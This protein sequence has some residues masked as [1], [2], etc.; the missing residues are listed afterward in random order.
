MRYL[1]NCDCNSPA[2]IIQEIAKLVLEELGK[3]K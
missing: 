1:T 2:Q 3:R